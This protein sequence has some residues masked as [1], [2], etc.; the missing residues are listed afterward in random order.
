MKA[1]L[2][3]EL[4]RTEALQA[5]RSREV[6]RYAEPL[7]RG[8]N[9]GLV[10][11]WNDLQALSTR[12]G[13]D[14]LTATKG[15]ELKFPAPREESPGLF[16]MSAAVQLGARVSQ[17]PFALGD[18]RENANASAEWLSENGTPATAP[19]TLTFAPVSMQ[20]RQLYAQVDFSR[21]LWLMS[22]WPMERLVGRHLTALFSATIDQAAFVGA[23]VADPLGLKTHTAVTTD[24]WGTNGAAPTWA[25]LEASTTNVASSNAPENRPGWALSP[26][27]R[28]KLRNTQKFANCDA[29]CVGNEIDGAPVKVSTNLPD[30]LTKGTSNGICSMLVY[31][32]DWAELEIIT[33]G[34]G[35]ELL[36]DPYT[37][38]KQ[39]M[40]ALS[41]YWFGDV[42]VH[43]G[44]T[45][46]RILDA[47]C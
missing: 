20:A 6:A 28:Q 25:L 42:V 43:R 11:P 21:Q 37:G 16:A 2:L 3:L 41:A 39:G 38:K 46:R 10:V 47:L 45:F 17:L 32:A 33:F 5:P 29:I 27:A 13:L 18:A 36:F 24:A 26:K 12:A 8:P 9:G 22:G 34:G 14:T 35:V 31:G 4:L 44:A 23:G 15:A 40:V 7:A 1:P 19:Q 30:N